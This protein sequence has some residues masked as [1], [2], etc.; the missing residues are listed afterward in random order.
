MGPNCWNLLELGWTVQSL[1]G[2]ACVVIMHKIVFCLYEAGNGDGN[3]VPPRGTNVGVG[4]PWTTHLLCF[5][6]VK[7]VPVFMK[8]TINVHVF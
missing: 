5:G 4:C 2:A 3:S 8:W 1:F 6:T 7:T